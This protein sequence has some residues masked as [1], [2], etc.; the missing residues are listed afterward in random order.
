MKNTYPQMEQ[1]HL[2]QVVSEPK[3]PQALF[4]KHCCKGDQESA[5]NK[6]TSSFTYKVATRRGS[7]EN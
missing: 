3:H 5:F 2:K 1:A 6:E 7:T 4:Q